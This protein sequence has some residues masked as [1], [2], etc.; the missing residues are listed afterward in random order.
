MTREEAIKVL[1]NIK[2][3]IFIDTYFDEPEKIVSK[4]NEALEIAIKALE[5]QPCEDCISRAEVLKILEKEEFKGDAIYEIE[6]KLPPV[7]PK[8]ERWIPCAERLPEKDGCYLVTY[9]WK[10]SYSGDTYVET[11]MAVYREKPKEW[12][13]KDVIAWMPLPEPYKAESEDKG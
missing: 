10:G 13:C 7:T 2:F 9:K 1:K 8:A 6:K 12:D 5:Q 11:T 3:G 4:E